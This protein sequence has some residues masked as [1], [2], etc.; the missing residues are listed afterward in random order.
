M[1][2]DVLLAHKARPQCTM[3]AVI[4]APDGTF[5]RTRGS[6]REYAEELDVRLCPFSDLKQEMKELLEKQPV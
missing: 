5:R 1:I 3:G 6:A 2:Y 4:C